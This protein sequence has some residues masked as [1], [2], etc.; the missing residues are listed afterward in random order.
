MKPSQY[1]I[2]AQSVADAIGIEVLT[3][4]Q[5]SQCPAWA[6]GK[7]RDRMRTR[8]DCADCGTVHGDKFRVTI[9]RKGTKGAALHFDFWASW[10]D[11]N[12]TAGQARKMNFEERK[13][14][15][16]VLLPSQLAHMADYERI[17]CQHKPSV[18]DVL[19]SVSSDL[20]MPTEADDVAEEF[21]DMKPSQAERIARHA[22]N[23]QAFFTEAE[24]SQLAEV[25]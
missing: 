23:L 15:H 7:R 14:R 10:S 2:Q 5:G 3:A 16:I 1:E 18:Y 6:D 13:A 20:S 11:C 24:R 4:F 17:K 19:C 22:R 25:Q 12:T 8:M 21:G 9:R